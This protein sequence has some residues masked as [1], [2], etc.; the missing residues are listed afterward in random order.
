MIKSLSEESE[1][2]AKTYSDSFDRITARWVRGGAGN[3]GGNHVEISRLGDGGMAVR[4]AKDPDG[5][6]LFFT[7]AEWDAFVGGVK[8][9]EFDL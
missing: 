4:D 9:G 2:N 1:M 8:D 6:I 3:E 5:P 7:P